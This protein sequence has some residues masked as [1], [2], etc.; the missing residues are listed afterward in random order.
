MLKIINFTLSKNCSI[1][2]IQ[3]YVRTFSK[4]HGKLKGNIPIILLCFS[5]KDI[6]KIHSLVHKKA[7]EQQGKVQRCDWGHVHTELGKPY[8]NLNS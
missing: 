4:L 5:T 3:K 6:I 7:S 2:I 1:A 8:E